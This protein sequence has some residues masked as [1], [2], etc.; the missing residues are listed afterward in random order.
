MHLSYIFLQDLTLAAT[1]ARPS[2]LFVED[3]KSKPAFSKDRYGSVSRFYVVCNEDAAI[4]KDH[5]QLMIENYPG[6]RVVEIEGADHMVMFSKPQELFQ[7][8]LHITEDM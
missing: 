1:L 5:Q 3:L 4:V 6:S 7:S 2:S 8:L